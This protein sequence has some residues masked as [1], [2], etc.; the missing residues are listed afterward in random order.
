MWS[1][2]NRDGYSDRSAQQVN[3]WPGK[4]EA[5]RNIMAGLFSIYYEPNPPGRAYDR[6]KLIRFR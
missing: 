4:K 3:Q 5:R 1:E 2:R 6:P